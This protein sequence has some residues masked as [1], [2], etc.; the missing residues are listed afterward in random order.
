MCEDANLIDVP[1]RI[2]NRDSGV[3]H[4]AF[5]AAVDIAPVEELTW[6]YGCAFRKPEIN[7]V[8]EVLPF[9]CKC[10]STLCRDIIR[11]E[12]AICLQLDIFPCV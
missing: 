5:F 12:P 10:G 11:D 6:D 1:V 3:Y 9:R 4:V 8:D 2:G 7:V